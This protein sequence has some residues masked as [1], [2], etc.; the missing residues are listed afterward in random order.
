MMAEAISKL[1]LEYLWWLD[2][3]IHSENSAGNSPCNVAKRRIQATEL[4][5]TNKNG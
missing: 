2:V 1:A 5:L 4:N 3:L